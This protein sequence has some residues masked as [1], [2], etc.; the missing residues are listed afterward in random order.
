MPNIVIYWTGL[1]SWCKGYSNEAMLLQGWSNRYKNFTIVITNWL[2]VN[3]CHVQR[4]MQY[5]SLINAF[6]HNLTQDNFEDTNDIIKR[7]KSKDRQ[8]NGQKK[9]NKRTNNALYYITQKIK[10]R[11]TWSPLKPAMNAG[12][13]IRWAVPAPHVAS[14]V[15][16]LL[17]TRW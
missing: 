1:S 8:Y 17:Q 4:W 16:F 2:T 5:P 11:A 13:P 3:V 12:N 14:V 7:R 15:L 6:T 10:D 9:K